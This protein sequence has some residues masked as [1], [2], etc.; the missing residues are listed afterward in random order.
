MDDTVTDMPFPLSGQNV[1]GEFG[2]PPG[3][4]A[5]KGVNCRGFDPI[6]RRLRGGSR[7]GL[8]KFLPVT[9][10]GTHL[11]QH[12]DVIVDPTVD[13]LPAD[14]S[15]ADAT[16]PD[17][18]DPARNPYGRLVRAG[19]SGVGLLRH[20]PP[21]PGRF[22]QKQSTFVST[23]S[24]GVNTSTGSV[25]FDNPV[26]AGNLVVVAV[27]Y[28][29]GSSCTPT[30]A[31]AGVTDTAGT[32]YAKAAEGRSSTVAP[33]AAVIFYGIVP[34][35]G[36]GADTVTVTVTT[37]GGPADDVGPFSVDVLEYR[38][39]AQ[40]G[41]LG[42]AAADGGTFTWTGDFTLT[43]GAVQATRDNSIVVAVA[44][45][46]FPSAPPSTR[47]VGPAPAFTTDP[48]PTGRSVGTAA[49]TVFDLIPVEASLIGI[50][51]T[52]AVGGGS[53]NGS[54]MHWAMAAASFSPP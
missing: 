1:A 32:A 39:V 6:A 51:P 46:N 41:P 50:T 13:A 47:T 25:A 40:S 33:S 53:P 10:A 35:T 49:F 8:T 11:I 38:L 23:T 29:P 36:G 52:F 15:D 43:P 3:M 21:T 2:A 24:L 7:P 19:G 42:G 26:T 37:D 14:F 28:S 4:T 31:A 48:R 20:K 18:T 17:P 34:V 22:V 12:L 9:P 5:V 30:F 54:A 45:G 16:Y 44:N 27:R